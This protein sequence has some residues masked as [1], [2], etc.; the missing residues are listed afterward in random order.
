MTDDDIRKALLKA[1]A[2]LDQDDSM[3]REGF[4][5]LDPTARLFFGKM[6]HAEHARLV[7]TNDLTT[8]MVYRLAMN[9]YMRAMLSV[10]PGE[11]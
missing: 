11:V 3:L 8:A 5:K 1:S 7:A 10:A 9:A 2:D 4:T 6:V